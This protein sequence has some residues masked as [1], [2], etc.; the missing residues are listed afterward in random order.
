LCA[1]VLIRCCVNAWSSVLSAHRLHTTVLGTPSLP[2]SLPISRHFNAG[3]RIMAPPI[4]VPAIDFTVAAWFNWTTNP[5]PYYSGIQ[6]GGYSWELRV[7]NDGRFAV[8]FY[9]AISPDVFTETTTPLTYNDGEWHHVTGILRSGLAEL[10][11]DGVLVG[12]GSAPPRQVVRCPGATSEPEAASYHG[13]V[14][15]A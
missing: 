8:V 9:E 6:G 2:G 14:Q 13:C 1:S 12:R 7:Q 15:E 10:Y 5:S 4:L 3:D 11:V